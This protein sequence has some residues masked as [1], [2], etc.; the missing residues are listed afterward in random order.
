[1]PEEADVNR[2]DSVKLTCIARGSPAPEFTWYHDGVEVNITDVRLSITT[3]PEGVEP[4]FI[5]VTSDL[6]IDMADRG[7]RGTYT[8]V[9][10]N[11]V[12]GREV[13]DTQEYTLTVNCKSSVIICV[14]KK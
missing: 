4:D 2:T 8:C 10:T 12:Y 6:T 5:V 13:N 11:M 7:D 9:T 14:S 1:M 3:T